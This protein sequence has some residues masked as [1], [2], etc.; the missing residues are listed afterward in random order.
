MAR[1]LYSE[2]S[3]LIQA[4]LNNKQK[5]EMNPSDENAQKWFD[6]FEERIEAFV[7][8]YMPR[9]SGY[10]SGTK[11]DFDSSHA[12]KLVFTTAFHH[13]D[14]WG[15]YDGWTDHTVII[16]P[17][18]SSKYHIRISGRNRND[19][20][21]MMYQDF[22]NAL[23]Y[24]VE[25]DI[26]KKSHWVAQEHKVEVKS[27]WIDQSRMRWFTVA[28]GKEIHSAT[29]FE[30]GLCPLEACRLA[31]VNYCQN[32]ANAMRLVKFIRLVRLK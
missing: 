26:L 19:I 15:G 2:L 25:W 27:E 11:I 9:G 14:E 5:L 23:T 28:N 16:T 12:E 30:N 7:R 24:D 31:A 21:E 18:L 22:D 20:K 32:T 3:T 13:M 17:S 1:Y 8:D 10:N 6:E 4:R 29:S